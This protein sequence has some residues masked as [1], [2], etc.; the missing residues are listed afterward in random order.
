MKSKLLLLSLM[1]VLV[2]S[3]VFAQTVQ[4]SGRVTNA[5][6]DEPLNSV[7]ILADKKVSSVAVKPDGTYTIKVDAKATTLIFSFVGFVTQTVDIN[8]RTQIDV[9]M[10]PS[11]AALDDVVVI[12]Y[13]T[14]RKSSVTGAVSKYTNEKLDEAPVSRLDQ[15]LQGK[16]AGVS[17]QNLSSESGAAPRIRVRGLNSIN[18]GADP[19]V[20]V[21][22]HPV[23]D[24]LAF[25]NMADVQ[26]V[27]VLKDAASAAIYGSRGANGVIIITTK[28]GKVDK[29]KYTVKVSSGVRSP[30]KTQD[31]MTVSEYVKLMFDEAAMRNNDPSVAAN[32]K[33]LITNNERAQYVIENTIMGGVP[34]DWQKEGVRNANVSNV[35]MNV[36]GGK[37][38]SKYFFSAGYNKEEGMMFHSDYEKLSI[39]GKYET[40]LGK[41]V[42]LN[43]NMNPTYSRRERPANNYIDFV[44]FPSYMPARHT[45]ASA[46]FVN[47][48]PTWASVR[49]GDWAQAGHFNGRVYTGTMPD[50]SIW[51]TT[52]ASDP[53]NSSNNNPKSVME[54]RDIN[55]SDYRML[56][57]GDLTITLLKDLEF[58]TTGSAYVTYTDGLDFAQTSNNRA[59]DVNRGVYTNRLFI[60]LLSE[61]TLNYNK[62]F[63]DHSFTGLL[64]F[65]AQKT[66]VNLAR[67]EATNFAS[68]NI[69]TLNTATV[70]VAPSVDPSDGS[71]NGSY[72]LEN[73]VGLL[74]YLGRVTYGYKD[75]YLFQAS[76]RRDGSSKFAP[77]RKWGTFP[78]VSAGWVI[79]KE[80]F[81]D[82]VNWIS[83]L[84]LR[85]SYGATGNNNI[86]DFAFVDLL[87]GGNYPFG[88]GGTVNNGQL[89]SS[90][91]LSNPDITWERT[92]QYNLGL[93]LSMF[94][95]AVSLS[96]EVY[97][98]KSDR[99]LLKQNVMAFAGADKAWNNIGQVQNRGFELELTTNNFKHKNFSWTTTANLATYKNK[100]L[101]FGATGSE[102]TSG[103]G[104]EVYVSQVGHPTIIFWGYKTNG[105]WLSQTEA[106]AV[107]AEEQARY[108]VVSGTVPNYYTAGGLRFVD[109]N[110]D[111]RITPDDRTEIGSP[112]P[113]FTWGLNNS[114]SYKNFDLSFLLQGVQGVDVINGDAR[115]NESRRYNRK[116]VDNRWVSPMFPGDGKTPYYT[117]GATLWTISDYAV[118]DASYWALRE[119]IVG[120]K[121]PKKL[122]STLKLSSVRLYASV[123]NAFVHWADNYRGINPEARMTSGST[124]SSP[125]VDGYQRGSFPMPR[126]ILFGLDLN[127]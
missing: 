11:T 7:S 53:F 46:A 6:N 104:S 125:L 111:G 40:Q 27:E 102:T 34:T 35:Q 92:F 105:V 24:G 32:R 120:Y 52:S 5:S 76:F 29:T 97:Q 56:T 21:D 61:N 37:K 66:K 36:S 96:A 67:T 78:S 13:G 109:L 28:S 39:R 81:M 85:G 127:F 26:S 55:S 19:L 117:N 122:A 16:V 50:G 10:L 118:E 1:L 82:N 93:D 113:D 80:K 58:K 23:P 30:Y 3:S 126:T 31:M 43:V 65:T 42:K 60:D 115:Y 99:L 77:G 25:V 4:I 89:P 84:K 94:R 70:I 8:G 54:T 87:Y 45:V 112:F 48:N 88:V 68:D 98:S 86:V 110:N 41:K 69:R 63:R 14:Q 47:Q 100:L 114:L 51:T 74:S 72:T 91:I 106:D 75:K 17:I 18:A 103:E 121:L 57:S 44:R 101:D 64:G 49:P 123:Q 79:S 73:N 124:Y 108:G 9:R 38:D 107:K 22:G 2:V 95:N 116:Y 33:N 83:Q 59:G 12:G 20:V 71:Y 90:Q 15:A 119:V 62:R